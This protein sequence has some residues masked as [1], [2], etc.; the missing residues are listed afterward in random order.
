MAASP[1]DVRPATP[2]PAGER[3]T[4]EDVLPPVSDRQRT[5]LGTTVAAIGMLAVLLG[6]AQAAPAVRAP[7]VLLAALLLPGYPI[8]ARLRLDLPTMIA[9]DVCLSLALDAALALLTVWGKVWE[10]AVSAL[11]L[12]CFGV[13]GTLVSLTAIRHDDDV[14]PPS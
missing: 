1:G 12:A 8:V 14:P 7:A 11:V 2:S 10:P 13:G 9:A 5:V 3:E 6:A 4:G